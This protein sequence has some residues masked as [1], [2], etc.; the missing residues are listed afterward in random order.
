MKFMHV[1][2]LHLESPFKG[3][4]GNDMPNQLNKDIL[5]ST[6]DSFASVVKD[7]INEKVDFLL[8]VGDLFDSDNPS[9]KAKLFLQEQFEKLNEFDIPVF[10]SYGNHDY[11]SNELGI[12]PQNVYVFPDKVNNKIVQIKN[13]SVGICGF[14]YTDK[15]IDA[16][17]INDYPIKSNVDYQIGM[18]HGDDAT[19]SHYANFSVNQL[20]SK[21][22]D[23]W[24]LGH[25]HKRQQLNANP[26]IWYSGNTQGRHQNESGDKG[27]LIID[28]DTNK[29]QFN[30]TSK[31]NW[32]NLELQL[33]NM[34]EMQ[35]IQVI[36]NA[37]IK[38]GFKKMNLLKLDIYFQKLPQ[39]S[40]DDLLEMLQDNLKDKYQD[41]NAWVYNI[42]FRSVK[43]NFNLIGDKYWKLT[44]D[45]V[46]NTDNISASASS[47][48]KYS[49]I[50]EYFSKND[51]ISE[52]NQLSKNI[53][54]GDEMKGDE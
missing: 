54:M 40:N 23:Y 20:L 8:I 27:Y 47:L 7:A 16:I 26:P 49:F 22:Y 29:V 4:L 39:L 36:L 37:I 9:P 25:I 19:E 2:D 17:K 45:K 13:K 50:K 38:Q 35:L 44:Q 5:N 6:F 46:F 28:T 42:N 34:S 41:L 21:N 15:W 11:H 32:S 43:N 3:M 52:L 48:F 53:L 31:I 24:A 30:A 12:Y 51:N 10:M 18:F 33:D 1:A 14:S